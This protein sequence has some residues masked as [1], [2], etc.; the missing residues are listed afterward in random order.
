MVARASVKGNPEG[1]G[2]KTQIFYDRDTPAVRMQSNTEPSEGGS[3][4]RSSIGARILIQP[5][6]TR[7]SPAK[8][9]KFIAN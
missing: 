6:P 5:E 8:N 7:Y 3:I 9:S 4:D 1:V 2:V